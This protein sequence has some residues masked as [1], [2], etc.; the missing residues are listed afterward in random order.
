MDKQQTIKKE[1]KIE[2]IGLHLGQVVTMCLKPAEVDSGIVFRRL[3]L[4]P[5]V[6]VPITVNGIQEALL[7]SALVQDNVQISTIE[8]L[9][10]ALCM[11]EVDNL[12][13]EIDSDEL[14]VMDGSSKPFLEAIER[15]GLLQQDKPRKFIKVL[16]PVRVEHEDKFAE[17]IPCD[18]T[19][20]RFEIQWDHPVIASTPSVVEFNGDYNWYKDEVSRARTF[21][22]VSQLE[23]LHAHNRAKGASLD[24]AIGVTDEGVMNKGGLRYK[25]EFVK[26]KLLD[27]IGDFYVGGAIIGCFNCYKSGHHLN[28]MLLRKLYQDQSN[29]EIIS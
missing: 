28:N 26:H 18:Q 27:A 24:N 2:G 6:D 15:V 9:M 10:S 21:G 4:I 12:L 17:V 11:L 14:P 3:D 5:S 7:C 25:D 13:V 22:L 23:Y 1:I 20:Y 29:Y 16:K 8:H 19:N